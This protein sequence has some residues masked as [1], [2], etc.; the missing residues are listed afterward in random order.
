MPNEANTLPAA[1]FGNGKVGFAAESRLSLDE[2][3]SLRFEAADGGAAFHLVVD[4]D[5][6][7]KS[8]WLSVEKRPCEENARANLLS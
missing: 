4:R 7:L 5:R 6:R 3:D 8:R 1:L 2:I